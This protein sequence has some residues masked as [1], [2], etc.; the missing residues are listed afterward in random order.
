MKAP[1]KSE[2]AYTHKYAPFDAYLDAAL[3]LLNEHGV[4]LSQVPTMK[5]KKV[6][7]KIVIWTWLIHESGAGMMGARMV[8]PLSALPRK[9]K[10]KS[11]DQKWR[12]AGEEAPEEESEAETAVVPV[13]PN[14]IPLGMWDMGSA[15]T[16]AK[17]YAFGA[18]IALHSRGED[19]D[20]HA[21]A[22]QKTDPPPAKKQTSTWGAAPENTKAAVTEP[23][24][25]RVA[26]ERF[27]VRTPREG[28]KK[29]D[30]VDALYPN[31][32]RHRV[33]LL[34]LAGADPNGRDWA[35]S[36]L[37]KSQQAPV[38]KPSPSEAVQ[39]LK[40]GDRQ[41]PE[42]ETSSGG[43]WKEGGK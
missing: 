23:T 41:S 6:N 34:S 37:P 5:G 43:N 2:D 11:K 7:R 3:P 13:D 29:D 28:F 16:Y 32:V 19:D 4:L 15:I 17:R 33:K 27:V 38:P 36:L 9:K 30:I 21:A 18:F 40:A 42:P 24:V 12:P 20:G 8:F 22:G 25:L 1:V 14:E 26:G 10:E 31:G 35:Y 39:G